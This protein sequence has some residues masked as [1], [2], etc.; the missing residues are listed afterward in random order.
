M[1]R[2]EGILQMLYHSLL[3]T[4]YFSTVSRGTKSKPPKTKIYCDSEIE[5]AE[6]VHLACFMGAT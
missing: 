5:T 2:G 6:C 4:L 1:N 3:I